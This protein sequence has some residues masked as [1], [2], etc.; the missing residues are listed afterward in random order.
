MVSRFLRWLW[1]DKT[2]SAEFPVPVCQLVIFQCV[3][4]GICLL[5]AGSRHWWMEQ[6][7]KTEGIQTDSV[8]ITEIWV[9]EYEGSEGG[10]RTDYCYRYRY[11][12]QFGHVHEHVA[13]TELSRWEKLVAGA[14]L[15][16]IEYLASAPKTHRYLSE[17]GMGRIYVLLGVALLVAV[18]PIRL[19]YEVV[20]HLFE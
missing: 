20:I 8:T 6:Y 18:V 12:D 7:Y 11:T 10:K 5:I 1:T 2:P 9:R 17:R 19:A 13:S 14:R 4:V 16:T 15:P 3:M